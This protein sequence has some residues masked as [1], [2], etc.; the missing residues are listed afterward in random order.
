MVVFLPD[1]ISG[2]ERLEDSLTAEKLQT[3]LGSF[4]NTTVEVALPK[5][6]LNQQFELSKVLPQLGIKDLFREGNYIL[7]YFQNSLILLL[8]IQ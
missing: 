3:W 1:E 7:L 4:E 6:R 2:L 8:I 5:F